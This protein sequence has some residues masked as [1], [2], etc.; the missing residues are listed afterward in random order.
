MDLFDTPC[1]EELWDSC[2]TVELDPLELFEVC[3]KAEARDA[4]ETEKALFFIGCFR[5]R[6]FR[7]DI[8]ISSIDSC[9]MQCF[10]RNAWK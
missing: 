3:V 7:E 4:I 1:F 9:Y 6:V 5:L 2:V 10:G 8:V